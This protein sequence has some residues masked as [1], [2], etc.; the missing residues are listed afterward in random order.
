MCVFNTLIHF[1]NYTILLIRRIQL[2]GRLNV[3]GEITFRGG[4][5]LEAD[6][7]SG[8]SA[9]WDAGAAGTGGVRHRAGVFGW[10]IPSYFTNEMDNILEPNGPEATDILPCAS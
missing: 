2:L 4:R 9:F 3:A 8:R 5:Y 10:N 6:G 1:L 7:V